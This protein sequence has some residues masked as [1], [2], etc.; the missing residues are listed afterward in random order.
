MRIMSPPKFI[1]N[2]SLI[3]RLI[4]TL[5]VF[6]C[7]LAPHAG[8]PG[9]H[10]GVISTG[11]G[12]ALVCNRVLQQTTVSSYVRG[13]AGAAAHTTP[14]HHTRPHAMRAHLIHTAAL[15]LKRSTCLHTRPISCATP[16]CFAGKRTTTRVN[17]HEVSRLGL[18]LAP[19]E[20]QPQP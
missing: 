5:T 1:M 13:D 9:S 18:G 11:K 14:L 17:L 8:R 10:C 2:I 3:L 4:I 12:I 7:S 6:E 20:R 15:L 16:S 19:H